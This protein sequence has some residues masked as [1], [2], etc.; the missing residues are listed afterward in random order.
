M[1]VVDVLACL[2]TGHD[3]FKRRSGSLPHA[4]PQHGGPVESRSQSRTTNGDGDGDDGSGSDSD[5]EL[6]LLE[7]I[8]A[9]QAR[10]YICI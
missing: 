2:L 10:A 7:Q 5:V 3:A 8:N 6:L 1:V 9:M 4:D